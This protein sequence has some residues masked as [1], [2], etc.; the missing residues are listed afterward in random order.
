ML[1]EQSMAAVNEWRHALGDSLAMNRRPEHGMPPCPECEVGW[2]TRFSIGCLC[3]HPP[4]VWAVTAEAV[5]AAHAAPALAALH[6]PEPGRPVGALD[7]V[8]PDQRHGND[9]VHGH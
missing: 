5:R 6:L 3:L 8:A 7:L 4:A 1:D 2:V 9:L